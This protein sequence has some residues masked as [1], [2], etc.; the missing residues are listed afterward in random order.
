MS[1]S[2]KLFS[3]QNKTNVHNTQWQ[4]VFVLD[5]YCIVI[6]ELFNLLIFGLDTTG[7]GE[8]GKMRELPE[9]LGLVSGQSCV[10]LPHSL[11]E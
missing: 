11:S 8:R 3:C 10:S 1:L 5:R 2:S 4:T 9:V 7:D 6:I